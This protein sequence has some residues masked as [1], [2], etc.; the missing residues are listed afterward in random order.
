M[1]KEITKK[2]MDDLII[3]INDIDVDET[4]SID[5]EIDLYANK[6]IKNEK[7]INS[8]LNTNVGIDISSYNNPNDFVDDSLNILK[9]ELFENQ[10]E[11]PTRFI[12]NKP[13]SS[14]K[15]SCTAETAI[16]ENIDKGIEVNSNNNDKYIQKDSELSCKVSEEKAIENNIINSED[17]KS[18][19]QSKNNK[20]NKMIA[21]T[22]AAILIGVGGSYTYKT[23]KNFKAE[24]V[25]LSELNK[26]SLDLKLIIDTV[27]E[28]GG[29][30][31]QLNWKEVASILS[32]QTNNYP[33][34]IEKNNVLSVCSLFLD[35]EE[36]IVKGLNDV[37]DSLDMKSKQ[38][39]RIFDY[40]EDL[41]EYGYT[42][43][44]LALDSPQMQFINSI[45]VG[46]FESYKKTKI[47][48]SITI[49]QAIL[50]SNWGSSNLAKES[51]NLFGIKADSSWKG[52]FVTFETKEFHD[53]MIKDKFRKYQNVSDAIMDH[54]EFLK[55][56]P[57]YEAGGVFEAKT[58]KAQ[59]L[60]LQES[61]YSTAQDED[62][63]KTYASMLERLIRQYNLQLLDWEVKYFNK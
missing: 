3:S 45:K 8:V 20:N 18:L 19:K 53:T 4:E 17:D 16:F 56:N 49:A 37:V 7:K 24:Q 46:A 61:G 39:K 14:R 54:S 27:D 2:D 21:I 55:A 15:V 51:N 38:K 10:S 13:E 1:T 11:I 58:Y 47:L 5:T 30:D 57:R 48:P 34:L 23:Y 28:Y 25:R 36:G 52:E 50:E 42:P 9:E 62:G 6:Y 40:Y 43:E 35:K 12:N 22:I 32:V 44:K 33:D 41:T 63:N 31:Y 26:D 60:A 59:A 29:T